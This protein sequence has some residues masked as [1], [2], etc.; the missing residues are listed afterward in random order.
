MAYI[1]KVRGAAVEV[2]ET[3]GER[4]F[5]CTSCGHPLEN[6]EM[7]SQRCTTCGED[8]DPEAYDLDEYDEEDDE[9]DSY[10]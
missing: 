3:D 7:R 5:C 2:V 9:E 4:L 1:A 8:L 6:S 10:G